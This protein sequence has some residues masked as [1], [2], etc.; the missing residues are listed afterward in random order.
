MPHC[1]ANDSKWG[2]CNLFFSPYFLSGLIAVIQKQLKNSIPR[3]QPKKVTGNTG[4]M[5]RTEVS[6]VIWIGRSKIHAPAKASVNMRNFA[7]KNIKIA[8]ESKWPCLDTA[9]KI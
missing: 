2:K 8:F 3:A 1:R 4:G 9:L 5:D 6:L 7:H